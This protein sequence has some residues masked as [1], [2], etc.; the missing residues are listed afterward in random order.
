MN[1][2]LRKIHHKPFDAMFTANLRR[3]LSGLRYALSLCDNSNV[4]CEVRVIWIMLVSWKTPKGSPALLLHLFAVTFCQERKL[5][6]LDH[7]KRAK[8]VTAEPA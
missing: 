3:A 8:I 5:S 1:A 7:S 6:L 2:H 4:E